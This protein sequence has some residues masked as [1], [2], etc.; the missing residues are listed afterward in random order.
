M[1]V[2]TFTAAAM[3]VALDGL[4][5]VAS[6]ANSNGVNGAAYS[7]TGGSGGADTAANAELLKGVATSSRLYSFLTTSFATQAALDQA[8]A[9][10]GIVASGSNVAGIR[11]VTAAP[12]VPDATVATISVAGGA[13]RLSIS[14]S[15]SQ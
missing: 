7:F 3:P 13:V 6:G 4:A 10:L 2:L 15:I 9:A 8:A 5:G 14:Q 12:G 11:F 1:A